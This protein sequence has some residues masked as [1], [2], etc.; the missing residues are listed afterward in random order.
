[1]KSDFLFV[2]C[3][4]GAE[5]TLKREVEFRHPKLKPAFSRPGIVT[6]KGDQPF[7]LDFKLNSILARIY[8][9]SFGK[10]TAEK[11]KELIAWATLAQSWSRTGE[12][13]SESP[14][15]KLDDK[16]LDVIT[17][18]DGEIWLGCHIHREGMSP[19]A[20]G[21]FPENLKPEG[22]P[23]RAYLKLVEAIE[24]FSIPFKRGQKALEIGSAPGGAC[25]GLLERGLSVWGVDPGDM[26]PSIVHH[27]GFIWIKN[28]INQ[29]H[30]QDLPSNLDWVLLD[31]NIEPQDALSALEKLLKKLTYRPLGLLL[32]L[33][34][35]RWD[36]LLNLDHP[37]ERIEALGYR[38]Q[39]AKQLSNNAQECCV[40]LL[41]TH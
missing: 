9:L 15:A 19:R 30:S 38:V 13:D 31:M 28:S 29:L 23:S 26:H 1:M 7:T 22:A 33:K 3:Q 18:D 25:Y 5:A 35:N 16:V 11:E 34:L 37:L 2:G 17:I 21:F 36:M 27:H 4:A 14:L 20:G 8:G 10:K 32:T 39:G 40:F 6:F 12:P 24:R 41:P